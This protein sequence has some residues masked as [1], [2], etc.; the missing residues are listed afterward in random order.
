MPLQDDVFIDKYVNKKQCFQSSCNEN[1]ILFD[2]FE[3]EDY[4]LPEKSKYYNSSFYLVFFVKKGVFKAIIDGVEVNVEENDCL[5]V[6]P[7]TT[8]ALIKSKATI[9]TFI[10]RSHVVANIYNKLHIAVKNRM[11]SF[12]FYHHK[13]DKDVINDFQIIYNQMK[14]ESLRKPYK[15][16]EMTMREYVSIYIIHMVSLFNKYPH[17]EYYKNTRQRAIYIKMLE[18]LQVY[19]NKDRSV[20]FYADKLCITSKYLSNITMQ[21]TG[22]PASAIIDSFVMFRAKIMLYDGELNIKKISDFL[23]FQSQSFFGRYFKRNT[24]MSPREFITKYNKR[25]YQSES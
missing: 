12:T 1:F 10:V 23:N 4:W 6:M 5:I 18:L 13:L 24:G 7:C 2:N 22:Y 11:S 16:Q 21:Y 9:F 20:A 8:L 19:Y 14:C 17:I 15:L 3:F 25:L